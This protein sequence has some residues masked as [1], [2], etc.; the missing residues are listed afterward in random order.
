MLPERET[1]GRNMNESGKGGAEPFVV[2]RFSVIRPLGSPLIRGDSHTGDLK[3]GKKAAPV[4][5]GL[6]GISNAAPRRP[7]GSLESPKL[8]KAYPN[9]H[10]RQST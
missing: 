4:E 1:S 10:H 6:S 8:Q 7:T 5:R 2:S 9:H 3:N